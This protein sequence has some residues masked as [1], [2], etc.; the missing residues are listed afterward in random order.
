MAD[1]AFSSPGIHAR[2]P[3][4]AAG[5]DAK[6]APRDERRD[7]ADDVLRTGYCFR[8]AS[9][10]E[11]TWASIW[12][13]VRGALAE[14]GDTAV[15]IR[16]IHRVSEICSHAVAS[17]VAKPQHSLPPCST[18]RVAGDWESRDLPSPSL[19]EEPTAR[20]YFEG[21]HE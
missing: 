5:S 17:P 11:D 19:S 16:S 18:I 20:P 15:N 6:E 13:K 14:R 8:E 9:S 3:L 1:E 12:E 4:R 10:P 2:L 21:P 7:S